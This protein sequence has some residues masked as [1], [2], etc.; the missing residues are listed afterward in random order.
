MTK[1]RTSGL[2]PG[3]H[4]SQEPCITV[5]GGR[6]SGLVFDGDNRDPA[7]PEHVQRLLRLLEL[8][9]LPARHEQKLLRA[10]RTER[11]A[12]DDV[13]LH[14]WG[15]VKQDDKSI[16]DLGDWRLRRFLRGLGMLPRWFGPPKFLAS[17]AQLRAVKAHSQL[18]RRINP[19]DLDVQSLCERLSRLGLTS[20][21]VE[22]DVEY[23]EEWVPAFPVRV[24]WSAVSSSQEDDLRGLADALLSLKRTVSLADVEQVLLDVKRSQP[25]W[26]RGYT[27]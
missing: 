10:A 12:L 3:L 14:V 24:D 20:A 5:A 6:N 4:E 23:D 22:R 7:A 26:L 27:A 13:A 2:G 21:L 17:Q 8:F 25:G 1:A 11:L 18:V 9:P 16:D 15:L 19:P